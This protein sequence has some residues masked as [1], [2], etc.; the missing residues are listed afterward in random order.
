[1]PFNKGGPVTDYKYCVGSGW[2]SLLDQLHAELAEA[3][4]DYETLQV[5]EKFGDLRV[6]VI[7]SMRNGGTREIISKYENLSSQTC[8]LCGQPGKH[9]NTS[10][11]KTLCEECNKN[12]RRIV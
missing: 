3:D 8:E 11:I 10:W 2:H 9:T 12:P 6:Y 7:S 4:P 1:M 5:K